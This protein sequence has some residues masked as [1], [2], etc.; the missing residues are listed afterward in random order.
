M[1][2]IEKNSRHVRQTF[3]L[4]VGVGREVWYKKY[5]DIL[6]VKYDRKKEKTKCRS[7]ALKFG[8][9]APITLFHSR[10]S[11]VFYTMEADFESIDILLEIGAHRV[12]HGTRNT[13]PANYIPC[14][15]FQHQS[16]PYHFPRWVILPAERDIFLVTHRHH[17]CD[18]D[19]VLTMQVAILSSCEC[20][21]GCV[22]RTWGSRAAQSLYYSL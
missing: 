16:S 8:G 22:R 10:K 20:E 15:A 19:I 7:S 4:L 18:I 11:R 12:Q 17:H 13:R 5:V 9:S 6:H 3:A 21:L 1:G 2:D 14:A